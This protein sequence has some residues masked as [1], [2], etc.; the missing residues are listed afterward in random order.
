M[1]ELLNEFLCKIHFFISILSHTSRNCL[2]FIRIILF[3]DWV[4]LIIINGKYLI[5]M[6][7]QLFSVYKKSKFLSYFLIL[8]FNC[9]SVV[10]NRYFNAFMKSLLMFFKYYSKQMK[11]K[12]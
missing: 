10:F 4:T 8:N 9:S 3:I 2:L 11:Y 7:I 6:K 12:I 5:E 1:L